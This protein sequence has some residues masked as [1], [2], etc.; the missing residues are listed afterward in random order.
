MHG[1]PFRFELFDFGFK[2]SLI[3]FGHKTVNSRCGFSIGDFDFSICSTYLTWILT[4]LI[5]LSFSSES[6]EMKEKS[7]LFK[8]NISLL[9]VGKS[10]G[11]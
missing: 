3:F 11:W 4:V 10:T 1:I 8:R 2:F 9:E 7:L 5:S 6:C